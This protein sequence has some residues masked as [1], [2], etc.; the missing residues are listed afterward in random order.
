MNRPEAVAKH[1]IQRAC[2]GSQARYVDDQ[3]A[4]QHDFDLT[5]PDGRKGIL[6]VT[7]ATLQI[8][9]Q[10][11]AQIAAA[12]RRGLLNATLCRHGWCIYLGLNANVRAVQQKADEYLAAIEAEART[13]FSSFT[14]SYESEAVRRIWEDLGVEAGTTAQWRQGPAIALM[15]PGYGGSPSPDAVS[16][17]VETEASKSDNLRKLTAAQ[18]R[19]SHIAVVFERLCFEG[20]AALCGC[21]PQGAAPVLPHQITHAWAIAA[22]RDADQYVA[23]LAAN[24]GPWRRLG[25]YAICENELA[26]TTN[27]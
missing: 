5:F 10:L 2:L 16:R 6:E 24:R 11:D 9:R 22:T 21:E 15:D 12:Q 14:D 20:W 4:G 19:E 7:R 1:L 18:G 3:S 23:W 25:Y 17:A 26:Q 8:Q 27:T 13:C